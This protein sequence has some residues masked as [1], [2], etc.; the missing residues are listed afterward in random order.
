MKN[1]S[2]QS[3]CPTL[4]VKVEESW[5][6]WC[7]LDAVIPRRFISVPRCFVD[8]KRRC[9]FHFPI[10]LFHLETS[11]ILHRARVNSHWDF[12]TVI[13]NS[14]C[15]QSSEM[16]EMDKI[17]SSTSLGISLNINLEHWIINAYQNSWNYHYLHYRLDE[18]ILILFCS[19]KLFT[20]VCTR[21]I[22]SILDKYTG[23]FGIQEDLLFLL[24][25][26]V[27]RWALH[28]CCSPVWWHSWFLVRW[29]PI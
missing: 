10:P 14:N 8:Y 6:W 11:F 27:H 15:L 18:H 4:W 23:L 7:V 22:L 19:I 3:T 28:F 26:V 21:I 13:W 29:N 25:R 12:A 1:Y 20:I 24:A 16:T 9:F 5:A 17:D 2:F